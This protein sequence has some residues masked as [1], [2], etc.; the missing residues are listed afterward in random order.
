MRKKKDVN[1]RIGANIQKA[2]EQANY[3]QEKLSEIIGLTPNH[4]SAIERGASGA[5][6]ETIE[7]LCCHLNISADS[8]FFGEDAKC[9]F[10]TRMAAQ[11]SRIHPDFQPQV[12]KIITALLKM[13]SI[14]MR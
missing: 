8:L 4:L 7:R 12:Q 3:T 11:L 5:S 14:G 13:Q 6:L 1:I 2:R 10:S 9:E